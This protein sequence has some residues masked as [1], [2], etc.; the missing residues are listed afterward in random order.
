MFRV[1]KFSEPNLDVKTVFVYFNGTFP[2]RAYPIKDTSLPR[3]MFPNA[4]RFYVRCKKNQAN[5]NYFKQ[6]YTGTNALGEEIKLSLV[7]DSL[8]IN[9]KKVEADVDAMYMPWIGFDGYQ[10]K[11]GKH[12][13]LFH[14]AIHQ[15]RK[16]IYIFINDPHNSSFN[17]I[18]YYLRN[19]EVLD[20]TGFDWFN[21]SE[22]SYEHVRFMPNDTPFIKAADG[23]YWWQ[24]HLKQVSDSFDITVT[25]LSDKIIYDLFYTPEM[26]HE[27]MH[28]DYSQCRGVWIGTCFE[29]RSDYINSVF[30]DGVLNFEF[31]GRGTEKYNFYSNK[32]AEDNNVENHMLPGIYANHDYSIYFSRGKF[33]NML[34][35][36]FYEPLLHGL[37]L[38]ISKVC[39]PYQEIFPTCPECYWSNEWDLK[40][41]VEETDLRDLWLRQINHLF[42]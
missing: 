42:G 3:R 38:F 29:E 39:D 37:P 15:F 1:Q 10:K 19:P 6:L 23:K 7:D 17:A 14:K 11:L 31:M 28:D 25:P 36:T 27:K 33:V 4:N 2:K 32:N 22:E 20:K 5:V 18:S 12:K 26:L 41:N 40:K 8:N 34:G 21:E 9:W 24:R 30:K 13:I 35:A 16:P